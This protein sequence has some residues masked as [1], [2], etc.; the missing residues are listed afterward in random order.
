[1]EGKK[2]ERKMEISAKNKRNEKERK[3]N[4]RSERKKER[5]TNKVKEAEIKV[6]IKEERGVAKGIR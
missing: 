6:R 1:M 4:K 2:E 5:K 3:G